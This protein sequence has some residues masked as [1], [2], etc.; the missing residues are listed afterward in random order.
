MADM[1]KS[2]GSARSSHIKLTNVTY[3]KDLSKILLTWAE[4]TESLF[5]EMQ[6]AIDHG[7]DTKLAQ[8]IARAE[9]KEKEGEKAKAGS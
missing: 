2:A 6:Q 9:E 7:N 3:G 8:L 5:K 1:L 4:E